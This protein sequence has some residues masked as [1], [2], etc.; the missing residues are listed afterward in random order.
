MSFEVAIGGGAKSL[1]E[2]PA[3]D[4]SVIPVSLGM[5]ERQPRFDP[6]CLK[7]TFVVTREHN[8]SWKKKDFN[9]DCSQEHTCG[10]YISGCHVAMCLARGEVHVFNCWS[11][12]G[13]SRVGPAI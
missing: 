12:A 2:E 13:G 7:A 4:A 11:C 5:T 10:S 1:L 6:F 9:G 8:F 3:L